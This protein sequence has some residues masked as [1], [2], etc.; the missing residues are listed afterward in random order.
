[1]KSK[2]MLKGFVIDFPNTLI[3]IESITSYEDD[4]H[5]EVRITDRN[6]IGYVENIHLT[7]HEFLNNNLNDQIIYHLGNSRQLGSGAISGESTAT[8]QE[9]DTH[10]DI[11]PPTDSIAAPT[12]PSAFWLELLVDPK[13]AKDYLVNA[14]ELGHYARWHGRYGRR[15]ANLIWYV[16]IIRVVLA[17]WQN[18]IMNFIDRLKRTPT[19]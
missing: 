11:F 5:V 4:H 15:N 1:M 3:K 12:P 6:G 19:G 13:I 9:D 14:E 2:L 7:T 16:Q 10:P 8:Q 18:P 17:Q